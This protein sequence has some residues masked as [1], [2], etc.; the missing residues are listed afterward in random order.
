MSDPHVRMVFWAPNPT[1]LEFAAKDKSRM[2]HGLGLA[3]FW[4]AVRALTL[5]RTCS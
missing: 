4:L 1:G 2:D 3:V 5:C